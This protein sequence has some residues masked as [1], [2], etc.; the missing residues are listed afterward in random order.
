VVEARDS[1]TGQLLG[2]AVDERE[3]SDMRPFIRNSVTNAAAFEQI[4]RRWA[5][6]SAD[7]L[8]ELKEL[9]PIDTSALQV[10]R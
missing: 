9:S 8:A 4:F 2:R 1:L 7:G 6:S 10:R 5:Q 3:S